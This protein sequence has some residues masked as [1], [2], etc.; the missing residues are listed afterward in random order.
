MDP[1]DFN[2]RVSFFF[3]PHQFQGF[4][5]KAIGRRADKEPISLPKGL[6]ED[7]FQTF[8]E[9]RV[10][11]WGRGCGMKGCFQAGIQQ[12]RFF[13]GKMGR[14]FPAG[15]VQKFHMHHL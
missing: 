3:L 11:K 9:I 13:S 5:F 8:G 6:G 10:Q 15:G 12:D 4:S 7:L 14:D 1:V 2:I